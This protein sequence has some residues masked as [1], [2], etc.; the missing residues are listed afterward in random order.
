MNVIIIEDEDLA[1]LSLEKLLKN[2]PFDITIIK[3]L[4]SV[5]ESIN[6]LSKNTCDLIFSDIHLGDGESFEIFKKLQIDTPIIF[7]TAYDHYVIKSFEF[8]AIDYLLKPYSKEKLYKAIE[9]HLKI[10]ENNG[11]KSELNSFLNSISEQ[12][13]DTKK[14]FLVSSGNKFLSININEIS[15]F[16]AQGKDLFLHTFSGKSYLYDDTISNLETFLPT[17]DFFKINRKYIVNFNS[18][19][20]IIKYDKNRIAIELNN[21]IQEEKIIVSTTKTTDFKNWLNN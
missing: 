3:R 21:S 9:K 10:T 11:L 5:N 8:Y 15:F 12:K 2:S 14:R 7:T 6:W 18:I 13:Q 19:K 4:E 16:M 20:N 17:K 1:V